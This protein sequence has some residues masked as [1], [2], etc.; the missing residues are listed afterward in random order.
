MYQRSSTHVVS[1]DAILK[2]IMGG[3]YEENGP[4]TYIAD[5]INASFP[6]LLMVQLGKRQVLATNEFDR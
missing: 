1:T 2:V 5:L 6:N 3:L 4:P